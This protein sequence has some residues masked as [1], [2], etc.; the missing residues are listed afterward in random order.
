MRI[1]DLSTNIE[2]NIKVADELSKQTHEKL[3]AIVT[4]IDHKEQLENIK[5]MDPTLPLYG[6]PIAVK[7][8][9]STLGIRTTASSRILDNYVPVLIQ[10]L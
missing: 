3:N 5:N 6:V 2:E 4:F 10:Q 9:I 1:Q 7:D 8:N